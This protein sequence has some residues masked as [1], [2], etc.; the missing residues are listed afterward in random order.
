MYIGNN[1]LKSS[2]PEPAGQFFSVK[3]DTNHSWVTG[4][5]FYSD[6]GPGP[7]QMGDNHKNMKIRWAPLQI[8]SSKTTGPENLRFTLKMLPDMVSRI[9]FIKIIIVPKGQEGPQ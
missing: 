1:L 8:F 5:Q 3:L 6:K 7:F 2:S 9:K 4:I